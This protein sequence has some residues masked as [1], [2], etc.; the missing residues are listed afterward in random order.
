[1]DIS[2]LQT[3]IPVGLIVVISSLVLT[4]Q[5]IAKNIKKNREEDSAKILQAAKEE[6]ALIKA[7]LEAR[8]EKIDAQ[9]ENLE[10]NVN[11]DI[12]HLRETYNNEIKNLGLKIEELRSELR[13]TH[14]QLVQLL[15][16]LIENHKKD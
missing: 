13:S 5:K 2:G 15:T 12:G 7:K 10:L 3:T 9:L 1:M 8:I 4:W 6:D 11:K 16:T 14:G